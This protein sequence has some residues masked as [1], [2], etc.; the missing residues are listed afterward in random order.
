MIQLSWSK[1]AFSLSNKTHYLCRETYIHHGQRKLPHLQ[2]RRFAAERRRTRC[3]PMEKINSEK[4]NEVPKTLLESCE[5]KVWSKDG[6]TMRVWSTSGK[7]NGQGQWP[8]KRS[9]KHQKNSE[10]TQQ[11]KIRSPLSRGRYEMTWGNNAK[12]METLLHNTN[13]LI[14]TV[15]IPTCNSIVAKLLYNYNQRPPQVFV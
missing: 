8:K 15:G 9:K 7:P 3:R 2:G 13:A 4:A 12:K 11:R 14:L 6:H 1:N 10:P 5:S